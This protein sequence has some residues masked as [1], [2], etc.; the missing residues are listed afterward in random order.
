MFSSYLQQFG[1]PP[2]ATAGLL[3]ILSVFVVQSA[4]IFSYVDCFPEPHVWIEFS[5]VVDVVGL[6]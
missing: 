1:R 2:L 4:S 5:A 3:V 6:R